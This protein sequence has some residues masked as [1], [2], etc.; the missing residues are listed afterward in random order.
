MALWQ[1]EI[2][3]DFWGIFQW[4]I[5]IKRI[6]DEETLFRKNFF[7]NKSVYSIVY[8]ISADQNEF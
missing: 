8:M 4:S 1:K 5:S 3:E 7:I 6:F 2:H